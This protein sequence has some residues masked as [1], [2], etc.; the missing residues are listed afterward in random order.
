MKPSLTHSQGKLNRIEKF[1]PMRPARNAPAC[2]GE[3]SPVVSG[4]AFVLSTCLSISLSAKSLMIQPALRQ[5]KAPSVNKLT[6]HKD[7]IKV[8]ELNA[9]PQ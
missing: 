6:V 1:S 5:L 2:L 9:S 8:G 7:G 4:L 3:S